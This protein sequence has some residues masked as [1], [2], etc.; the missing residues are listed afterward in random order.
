MSPASSRPVPHAQLHHCT[1]VSLLPLIRLWNDA[2]TMQGAGSQ[3]RCGWSHNKGHWQSTKAIRRSFLSRR[4]TLASLRSQFLMLSS[5]LSRYP[6]AL[7]VETKGQ[8]NH[9]S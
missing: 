7:A 2:L 6:L 4:K 8:T 5:R 9:T 3:F 1:L